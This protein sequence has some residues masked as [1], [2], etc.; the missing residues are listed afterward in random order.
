MRFD[1]R[2]DERGLEQIVNVAMSGALD[3][4][5][6]AFT[7]LRMDPQLFEEDNWN[8][9]V[10]FVERMRKGKDRSHEIGHDERI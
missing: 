6:V 3:N 7:Y 5:L 1:F 4:Q 9:F 8:K 10:A 2:Y